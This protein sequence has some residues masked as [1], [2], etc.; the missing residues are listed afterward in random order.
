MTQ[1]AESIADPSGFPNLFPGHAASVEAA[2]AEAQR[3]GSAPISLSDA[4]ENAESMLSRDVLE[5]MSPNSCNK[6]P[7]FLADDSKCSL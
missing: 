2:A 5:G 1:I 7:G 6:G 3:R 4:V